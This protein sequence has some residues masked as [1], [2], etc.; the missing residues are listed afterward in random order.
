MEQL[1]VAVGMAEKLRNS[2]ANN[3]ASNELL[4]ADRLVAAA[5]Q[6]ATTMAR[7]LDVAGGEGGN[8]SGR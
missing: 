7:A 1:E 8:S 5:Q 6:R 2:N 4:A 3:P